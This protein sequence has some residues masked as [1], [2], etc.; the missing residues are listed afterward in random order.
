MRGGEG[1]LAFRPKNG[2]LRTP[3]REGRKAP[4]LPSSLRSANRSD[5]SDG[6]FS[7]GGLV[8]GDH[9]ARLS[10]RFHAVKADDAPSFPF[11]L[12]A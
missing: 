6:S 1:Y 11:G 8:R 4:S 9:V 5:G 3:A 12:I 2:R 10:A 7:P